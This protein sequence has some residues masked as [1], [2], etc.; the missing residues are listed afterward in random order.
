MATQKKTTA[1]T[2]AKKPVAK[3]PVAKKPVAKKPAVAK[4]AGKE[5]GAA[6]K[7]PF[8]RAAMKVSPL[9]GMTVEDFTAKQL[10]G[11]QAEVARKLVDLV[12][13]AAP[14]S[15]AVIKWGQPIF[16]EN[17]PMAYI[18]P[19]KA[20]LTF[21]FWRGAEID[22]PKGLLTGGGDRMKHMKIAE[23]DALDEA[24]LAKMVKQAAALN[25][26]KGNPAMR[27]K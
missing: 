5:P 25:R 14:S 10:S 20:H 26:E 1:A 11:W 9:K 4:S 7:K 15:A 13:R 22:D 24:A 16:E 21:G 27:G 3:K 6:A 23:G 17:G 18:K 2:G 12:K 19:A 8:A